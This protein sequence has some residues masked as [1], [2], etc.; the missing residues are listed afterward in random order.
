MEQESREETDY[1]KER[2]ELLAQRELLQ[3]QWLHE[4]EF[5]QTF[6]CDYKPLICKSLYGDQGR[7]DKETDNFEA[8]IDNVSDSSRSS[9]QARE[10]VELCGLVFSHFVKIF[11]SF[12]LLFTVVFIF[13]FGCCS[14]SASQIIL[15]S[16]AL[17]LFFY[18]RSKS[19]S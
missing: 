11:G 5:Q 3:K 18:F 2:E 12:I 4:V 6:L 1:I 17:P 8:D 9:S 16:S 19:H 10:F 7:V 13:V 14:F 15:L